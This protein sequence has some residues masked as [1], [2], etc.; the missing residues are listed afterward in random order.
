MKLKLLKYWE[1]TPLLYSYAFILDPRAKMK[2]FFNMLELLTE[3]TGTF[4]SVYYGDVKDEMSRLY[5]K[6]EQR[7][8][9]KRSERPAIPSAALA[10]KR[11]QAWGRIFG[12]P[13]AS[14]A[15]SSSYAPSGLN[16]LTA[17][18]DSA[19][20]T[21]YG[22]DFD[23]LLWWRDHWLTYPVLSILARDVLSVPVSTVS[24]ESCFS[25]TARILED[26]R[27]RL[28][29]EHVEMLTCLKDWDLAARKEQHAPED[30]D[31]EALFESMY[32]DDGSE[33]SGAGGS[34]STAAG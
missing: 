21:D 23:I 3:Q 31:L 4:Y 13:G 24:S 1:T 27:R 11:K 32:L 2:G 33:G 6:Y 17:Y 16:E 14:P 30:T 18:M 25:C 15:S 26:R 12:G 22:E 7:Y 20:I 10:G 28:L 34:T 8:G 5:S 9:E 19:P 29:P